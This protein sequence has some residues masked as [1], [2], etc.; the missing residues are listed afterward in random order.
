MTSSIPF[1]IPYLSGTEKDH[2]EALL[3]SRDFVG[4]QK[5]TK[6][7]EQWFEENHGVSKALLTTSCT[8]ALEMSALLI[9]VQKDDEVIMP[10]YTFVS[11][12]NAFILRGAKIVF[13]DVEP[14]TMNMDASLI[15]SAITSRTKAIVPVHYAGN[16]C[17]MDKIMEIAEKYSLYVIEDAAQCVGAKYK[18]RFLG[19]I[20]HFGCYSFHATKNLNCGEGGLLAINDKSF[21]NKAEI[22]REKGTNRSNFLRGEVDKYSWIGIGSSYLLSELSAAFLY[23]QLPSLKQ[24]TA[25]RLILWYKYYDNLLNVEQIELPGITLHVEHNAHLFYIK[26]KDSEVMHSLKSFLNSQKISA[27]T[28]YVPLHSSKMGMANGVVSGECSVTETD[29]IRL[30]RLPLFFDMTL[31]DVERITSKIRGYFRA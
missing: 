9:D 22:I 27:V 23:A 25:H 21:E 29:N 3:K 31:H 1:N 15:V 26:L 11:T 17:D 19:T 5:Y 14:S 20:G 4:G 30:L 24:V 12:A 13:V 8:H 7:C 10:S 6:K 28:H 2:L 18:D 16:G